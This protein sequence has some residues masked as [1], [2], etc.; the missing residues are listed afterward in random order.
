MKNHTIC[1]SI[2]VALIFVLIICSLYT[3]DKVSSTSVCPE[4]Y[5]YDIASRRCRPVLTYP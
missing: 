2:V 5:L 3:S 4:G 1:I